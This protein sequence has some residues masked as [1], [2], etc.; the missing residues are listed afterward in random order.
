RDEPDNRERRRRER[1]EEVSRIAGIAEHPVE[2]EDRRGVYEDVAMRISR[3]RG[4]EQIRGAEGLAAGAID[5][6][7]PPRVAARE[8]ASEIDRV[9]MQLPRDRNREPDSYSDRRFDKARQISLLSL[10]FKRHHHDAQ[11]EADED[12]GV[13]GT[14]DCREPGEETEH[15]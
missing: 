1:V 9:L 6:R 2:P 10:M 7:H 12:G 15:Q 14:D 8:R 4:T 5:L 11:R 3:H 13:G